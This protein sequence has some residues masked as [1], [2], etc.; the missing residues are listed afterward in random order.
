MVR[1]SS[2]WNWLRIVPVDGLLGMTV[3]IAD[4]YLQREGFVIT[5]TV[6]YTFSNTMGM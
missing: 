2:G 4:H 1:V 3:F 6:K 5:C